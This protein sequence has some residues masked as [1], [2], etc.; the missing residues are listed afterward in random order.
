MLRRTV[1]HVQT[2]CQSAKTFRIHRW[3]G[4]PIGVQ[5]VI[6][7][8]GGVVFSMLPFKPWVKGVDM[9][10]PPTVVLPAGWPARVAPTLDATAPLSEVTGIAAVST[11]QG[12][13]LR[14]NYRGG[15]RPVIVPV[16]GTPWGTT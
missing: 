13:A 1:N 4:W 10:K 5:L 15:L 12:L 7:V 14:L 6:W 11:P 16:D 8:A 9:V 3:M 2:M